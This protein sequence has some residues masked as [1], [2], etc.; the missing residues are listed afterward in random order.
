MVTSPNT[1]QQ[2]ISVGVGVGDKASLERDIILQQE[3]HNARQKQ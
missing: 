1:I 2:N 3:I